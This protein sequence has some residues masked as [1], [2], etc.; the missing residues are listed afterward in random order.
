[1]D[2]NEVS[3]T[4]VPATPELTLFINA[5]GA[6]TKQFT[7]DVDGNLVKTESGQMAVGTARRIAIGDA[8]ALADLINTISSDQALA[9]GSMRS[10]LPAQVTVVTK[11]ALNGATAPDIISRSRDYLTFGQER[12]GFCL[13]DFDQKGITAEVRDKLEQSGGFVAALGTV[14]P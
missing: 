13:G 6:L 1:L 3:T 7:L 12:R 8:Q 4:P 11:K 10:G 2:P 14:I 5:H 9:L